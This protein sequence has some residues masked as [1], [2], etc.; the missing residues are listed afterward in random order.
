MTQLLGLVWCVLGFVVVFKLNACPYSI[1]LIRVNLCNLWIIIQKDWIPGNVTPPNRYALRRGPRQPGMTQYIAWRTC[2]GTFPHFHLQIS[3]RSSYSRSIITSSRYHLTT[4]SRRPPSPFHQS[5]DFTRECQINITPIRA[6]PRQSAPFI[7]ADL[8]EPLDPGFPGNRSIS[9]FMYVT[10]LL[11]RTLQL[12]TS[13]S[14]Y[15]PVARF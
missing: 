11:S 9:Y 10:L 14:I 5:T 4:S 12:L 3:Y 15:T 1:P 6:I 8:R 13:L 2:F 7:R